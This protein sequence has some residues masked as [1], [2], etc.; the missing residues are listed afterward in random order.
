MFD[1][2]KGVAW[3]FVNINTEQKKKQQSILIQQWDILSRWCALFMTPW[4]GNNSQIEKVS[5]SA[6]VETALQ[7]GR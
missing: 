3:H 5:W 7:N 6:P 2:F 1:F 4:R